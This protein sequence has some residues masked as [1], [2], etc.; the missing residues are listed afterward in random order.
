MITNH[1]LNR[2]ITALLGMWVSVVVAQAAW[3][4]KEPSVFGRDAQAVVMRT[5]GVIQVRFEGKLDWSLHGVGR[6]PVQAWES[7]LLKTRVKGTGDADLSVVRYDEK[8]Q[9]LDWA[10][11]ISSIKL[12]DQWQTVVTTILVPR[13]TAFIEPRLIGSG[14]VALDVELLEVDRNPEKMEIQTGEV[15]LA[16]AQ[17]SYGQEGFAFC[18]NGYTTER[19]SWLVLKVDTRA[20][21]VTFDL[22]NAENVK[23]YQATF[24]WQDRELHLSLSSEGPMYTQLPFPPAFRTKAGERI[25]VP[26]NEGMGYPVDDTSL[27][28]W[29]LI[30]FGG[31]GLCM[32]FYGVVN[33]ETGAGW[34]SIVETADDASVHFT[35]RGGLWQVGVNWW[36]Q[37]NAFG[38]TRKQRYC[39][40]EKGG[41]VAMCKRYRQYVQQLGRLKTFSE[42]VK[43][44][45]AIDKLI[46]A[47]N[48]WCW[49][50]KRRV[51]I[52]KELQAAGIERILWSGNGTAEQLAVMNSMTN[53]LT[54]RYDIYSDVMDP[55]NLSKVR[56]ASDEWATE[57]FPQ[58]ITWDRPDGTMRR[59]WGVELKEGTGMVYCVSLCDRQSLPYARKRVKEDLEKKPFACRFI[60][61]ATAC[62]WQECWNPAHPMTRSDSRAARVALLNVMSGE[63]GLVCGS[64]TGHDAV[65]PVCDY[66]EGML[67][68]GRYRVP[69]AGRRMHIIWDDVPEEVAKYQVGE[70]YR[71]PLWELVYH[72]CVVAQWYWGD[73]NNKLPKIWHKRDLFNALYGTP[74]MYMFD[75]NQLQKQKEQFAASYRIAA[76]VARLTG[77]SEMVDHQILTRD[78][79]VQQT[80]FANGVQVTVNFGVQPFKAADGRMLAPQGH[81]VDTPKTAQ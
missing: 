6:I 8:Q 15:Q 28:L 31:H 2:G 37:R 5:G 80:R 78:R 69:D 54:S 62:S 65:V 21:Q 41:H 39:F 66:F 70:T 40:L 67:S 59:A 60:D 46:G 9:A 61:T 76:P 75:Y 48:I 36:P 50:E 81:W 57:A 47:A 73:Y 20:D 32:A 4:L 26:E 16:G 34:M 53:V 49:D 44:R 63:F 29:D 25:I 64:E 19:S 43:T 7:Y 71:L 30:L 17:F 18:V 55:A 77:Y 11:G 38:A 35:K 45:P 74:P 27:S 58:D 14:A 52:V 51:E 56:W 42:K 72:D 68:I 22:L 10:Y 23:R 79:S 13:G 3:T 24:A 33:D 12:T 1:V